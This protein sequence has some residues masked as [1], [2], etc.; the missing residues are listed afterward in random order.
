MT[1][2]QSWELVIEEQPPTHSR[3][4]LTLYWN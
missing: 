1:Y 3:E 2:L 4:H